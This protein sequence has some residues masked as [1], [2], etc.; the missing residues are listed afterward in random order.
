MAERLPR[1]DAEADL[2]KRAIAE[3]LRTIP[4][5]WADFDLDRLT[6][7]QDNALFLLTAAGM[8]E[9]RGWLRSTIANHPTAFEVRFQATG[10]GGSGLICTSGWYGGLHVPLVGIK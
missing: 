6:V 9:R 1:T 7:I 10:E 5:T 3:L 8:V 2:L 4:E